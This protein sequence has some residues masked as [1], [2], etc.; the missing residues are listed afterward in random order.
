MPGVTRV[1]SAQISKGSAL[2]SMMSAA[3]NVQA[4]SNSSAHKGPQRS[5]RQACRAAGISSSTLTKLVIQTQ[6]QAWPCRRSA[7]TGFSP[8]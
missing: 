6:R 3:A 5:S 2:N 1:R 7:T 4:H 8:P